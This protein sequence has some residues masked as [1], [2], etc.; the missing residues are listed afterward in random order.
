MSTLNGKSSETRDTDSPLWFIKTKHGI[1]YVLGVIEVLLAFRFIFKLLGANTQNGFVSFLYSMAGIF[2]APF[3]GI[4]NPF[5]SP[6]IAAKSVLEPAVLI[7]MAVYAI[8]AR[9]L[10]GLIRLIAVRNGN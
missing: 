9:G 8:L 3:S 6:G 4:F 7:G 2:T 10:V 1:Y 5:V